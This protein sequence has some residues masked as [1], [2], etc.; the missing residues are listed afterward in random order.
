MINS[1]SGLNC[2]DVYFLSCMGCLGGTAVRSWDETFVSCPFQFLAPNYCYLVKPF[3]RYKDQSAE[4]VWWKFYFPDHLLWTLWHTRGLVLSVLNPLLLS[5]ISFCTWFR[6]AWHLC[7]LLVKTFFFFQ[8]HLGQF[9]NLTWLFLLTNAFFKS[10][11][12]Y[13]MRPWNI[14]LISHTMLVWYDVL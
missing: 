2:S 4:N 7:E 14:L 5:R 13:E 11:T 1:V 6:L 12:L 10:E 3:Q 9:V 8:G